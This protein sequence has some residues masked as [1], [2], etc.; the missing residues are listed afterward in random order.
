MTLDY[1]TNWKV[2]ICMYEY[3]VK[4]LSEFPTD[5][6]GIAKTPAARHLFNVNP[7]AKKLPKTTAKNNCP[8][9]HDLIAKL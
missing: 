6:N 1:K 4:M 8:G 7:E 3:I 9:F 5:I 2:K